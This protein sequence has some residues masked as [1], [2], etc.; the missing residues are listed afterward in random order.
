[1]QS[2]PN[3]NPEAA[4]NEVSFIEKCIGKGSLRLYSKNGSLICVHNGS[5]IMLHSEN[6]LNP[7]RASCVFAKYLSGRMDQG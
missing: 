5:T 2:V 7:E 6:F 1:M 4:K 3:W